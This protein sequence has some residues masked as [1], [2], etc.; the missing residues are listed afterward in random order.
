LSKFT[1]AELA[2]MKT[3]RIGRLA[4]VNQR[5]EPQNKPVGFRYNPELD[6]IDIGGP[7]N[8]KTQK[9]RN[10]ARNGLASFVVDDM[11]AQGVGGGIE[12]RAYA[13]VLPDGGE[14]VSPGFS[15]ELIRLTPKR[16]ITWD[17]SDRLPR[18]AR[19]VEQ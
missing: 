3:Q 13:E 12:I 19:N 16:I 4:T 8:G 11:T 7:A 6:T 1:E 9:F 14:T 2:Y 10:I 15:P 18:S 5:G 17:L